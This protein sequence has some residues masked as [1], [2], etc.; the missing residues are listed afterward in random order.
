MDESLE[1]AITWNM[2]ML[3]AVDP[4]IA[5]MAMMTKTTPD[6]PDLPIRSKM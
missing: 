5:G 6:F 1:Y 2:C 4:A 3:Q